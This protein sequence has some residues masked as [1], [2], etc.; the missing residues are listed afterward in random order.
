MV[1]KVC[2]GEMMLIGWEEVWGERVENLIE[3][4]VLGEGRDYGEDE[5]RVEEKVGE[6]KGEVEWGEGVVVWWEVEERVNIMGGSEFG[7]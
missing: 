1:K 4:F 5:G 7:E 3:R 2:G 6:V